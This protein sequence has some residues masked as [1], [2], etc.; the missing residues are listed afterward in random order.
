LTTLS[1]A[2]FAKD[3]AVQLP[4][5][6]ETYMTHVLKTYVRNLLLAPG[7]VLGLVGS[8]FA[9]GGGSGGAQSGTCGFM[10]QEIAFIRANLAN[11]VAT[12]PGGLFTPKR[13]WWAVVDRAGV[14]CDVDK[15]GDAWP[16]GHPIAIAKAGTANGF[17]NDALALS[18]A[19]LYAATQPGGLLYGLNNS[20]PFNPSYLAQRSG[21]GSVTGGI[22]TFGGGVALYFQGQAIGGLGISGDTPCIEHAIAY[23]MR[24]ALALAPPA[25]LNDNIV[26]PLGD[27]KPLG[28]E[29]PRC[30]F[31][32]RH[33]K[34]GQP[35]KGGDEKED[36]DDYGKNEGKYDGRYD[37]KG[38]KAR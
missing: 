19:N 34:G 1:A 16:D 31:D 33:G 23:R 12:V 18:T 22:I 10:T 13:V 5:R 21:I 37:G 2:A 8:S 24:S 17:S 38:L 26:Y 30:R 15:I 20:N 14:L 36:K 3:L 27:N 28:F 9:V 25:G 35:G 29:H 4:M 11:L 7:L 6:L 32:P